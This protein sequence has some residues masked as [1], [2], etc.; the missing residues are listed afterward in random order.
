MAA[1]RAL[2]TLAAQPLD[3]A[4]LHALASQLGSDCALFLH[5]A[6]VIMRGRGESVAA[7]PFVGTVLLLPALVFLR[8]STLEYVATWGDDLRRLAATPA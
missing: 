6:P 3:A 1:L 5:G 2:N 7:L 4:G 8:L